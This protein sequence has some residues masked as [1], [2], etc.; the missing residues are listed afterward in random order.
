MDIGQRVA[1]V[2]GGASGIG[3][4]LCLALA[5]HGAAG[6]VV[7]DVDGGG[8]AQVAAEIEAA[9]HR[10]LAVPTDMSIGRTTSRRWSR[11][12]RRPSGRS[13]CSAPTPGSSWT[14]A[15]RCRT[16]RGPASGPSTC[17]PRLRGPGRAAGHAGQGRGL[18]GHHRVRR[19]PAHRARLGPVRRDQARRGRR[20][21]S[22]CRSPTATGACGCRAC[23]R[24]RCA[25]TC[26]PRATARS[27]TMP[28]ERAGLGTPQAAVDGVLTADDVARASWR[29]SATSGS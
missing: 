27:R 2:T 16:R 25:P 4:S 11:G 18:P 14:A 21:P 15:S 6:V 13:T 23:A 28:A 17:R 9:G 12:P 26:S 3:R 29:P 5:E 22:G 8:A 24:R 20:S 19:R 7:A 10:A 1:V